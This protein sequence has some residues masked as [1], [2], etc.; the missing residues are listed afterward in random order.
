MLSFSLSHIEVLSISRKNNSCP[1]YQAKIVAIFSFNIL[2]QII[3]HDL[4]PSRKYVSFF[5]NQSCDKKLHN[6]FWQFV[7][8]WNLFL[9]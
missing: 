1:K 8:N 6:I 4:E 5:V 9:E 2:T 7:E 3:A